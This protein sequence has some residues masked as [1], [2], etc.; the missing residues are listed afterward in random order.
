MESAKAGAYRL[1]IILSIFSASIFFLN[2]NKKKNNTQTH[3]DLTGHKTGSVTKVSLEYAYEQ[4][5]PLFISRDID[6]IVKI[7]GQFKD[8]GAGGLVEKIIQD[9]SLSLSHE[10][11]MNIIFGAVAYCGVKKN[12]HYELLDLLL[13]YPLLQSDSSALLTLARSKYP[14]VI[15]MFINWGK[16]RQK[17][18]GHAGLLTKY[19]EQA[20]AKAIEENDCGAIELMLSK[21]VRLSHQTASEFLWDVVLNNKDSSLITLL[22]HHTQA[23]VNYADS[24][25]T[26]LIEA[27]EKNN[28]DMIRVL[29]DE[30]AVVDRVVDAEKGSALTIAMRNNYSSA[31]QLLREYGA[32]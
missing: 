21:K 13:K 6:L 31:E 7:V 28:T 32:A 1:L 2:N 26:L 20:F 25:K 29:L 10:D 17:N 9:N 12:M 18:N 27:V 15:A 23:D 14:D 3:I 5:G 16:D 11:K 30:G 19:V 22:V 24:G 4:M 8:Q